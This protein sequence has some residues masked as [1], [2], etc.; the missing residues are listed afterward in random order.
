MFSEPLPCDVSPCTDLCVDVHSDG[1][2]SYRCLCSEESG[3][4]LSRDLHTCI[5][6]MELSESRLDNE[7]NHI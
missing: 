5:G 2:P 7:G 6:K 1:G 3:R 4:V